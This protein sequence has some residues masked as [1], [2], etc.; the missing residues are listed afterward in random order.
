A[1]D[2]DDR[3]APRDVRVGLE[4]EPFRPDGA[5]E[6]VLPYGQRDAA[7][8][9]DRPP[10][11]ARGDEPQPRGLRRGR[12]SME[13]RVERRRHGAQAGYRGSL[14]RS[15]GEPERSRFSLIFRRPTEP[16]SA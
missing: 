8:R 15:T 10:R 7:R 11:D 4:P 3:V 2:L 1:V 9:E 6:L 13:G 12:A 14:A 5:A 16:P